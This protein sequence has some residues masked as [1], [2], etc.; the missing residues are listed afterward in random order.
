[1]SAFYYNLIAQGVPPHMAAA[2]SGIGPTPGTTTTIPPRS[3]YQTATTPQGGWGTTNYPGYK[4]YTG[5]GG[6]RAYSLAHPLPTMGGATPSYNQGAGAP[7]VTTPKAKATGASGAGSTTGR[8]ATPR[9]GGTTGSA[10]SSGTQTAA[11]VVST[12]SPPVTTVAPASFAP[13]AGA[14]ASAPAPPDP[15]AAMAAYQA[16][17]I[18]AALQG[19]HVAPGTTPAFVGL[20]AMFAALSPAQLASP[21]VQA[22]IAA[23]LAEAGAPA[24]TGGTLPAGAVSSAMMYNPDGTF[25]WD[26]YHQALAQGLK[27]Q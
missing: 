14:S 12:M 17:I 2:A 21:E 7:K 26:L 18:S 23:L 25:N 22:T 24:P 11:G 19:T 6:S 10:G 3:A 5:T 1:M 27:V 16:N 4:P 13:P 8:T 9:V 20:P 15:A